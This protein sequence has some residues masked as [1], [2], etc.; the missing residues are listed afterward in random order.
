MSPWTRDEAAK[1]VAGTGKPIPLAFSDGGDNAY[2]A[3]SPAS[4]A[5]ITRDCKRLRMIVANSGVVVSLDGGTT[6]HM[7]LP[8]NCMDDVGVDIPKAADIRIKRYTAGT[9]I[10]GLIVEVR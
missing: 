2:H 10:T 4:T 9:T 8:P 3:A 7:S 1:A 6:D 5:A